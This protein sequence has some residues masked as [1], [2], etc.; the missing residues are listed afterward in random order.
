VGMQAVI[1]SEQ[2]HQQVTILKLGHTMATVDT[3]HPMAGKTLSFTVEVVEVREASEVELSH[4]HVHGAG[5][6]H[7]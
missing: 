3:N 5:G 1:A 7:H 2:G 6:H 4:G